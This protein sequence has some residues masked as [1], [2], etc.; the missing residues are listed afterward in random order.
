[1]YTKVNTENTGD[2]VVADASTSLSKAEAAPIVHVPFG[3]AQGTGWV[4]AAL[5]LNLATERTGAGRHRRA[6]SWLDADA[7]SRVAVEGP[8]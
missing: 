1:M 8:G 7:K 6:T 2:S 5:M 4:M 3:S